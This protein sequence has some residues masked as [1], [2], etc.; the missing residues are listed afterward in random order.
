MIMSVSPREL[1]YFE[2]LFYYNTKK[3]EESHISECVLCTSC[4][5]VSPKTSF[6]ANQSET[7][8]TIICTTVKKEK[9]LSVHTF[10]G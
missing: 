6:G 7:K 9:V 2:P 1:F 4:F 5:G 3:N 10:D 8:R